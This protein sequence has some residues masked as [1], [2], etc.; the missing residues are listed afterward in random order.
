MNGE[1]NAILVYTFIA[2]I[3]LAKYDGWWWGVKGG[4]GVVWGNL[5]LPGGIHHG[6]LP[7]QEM[8]GGRARI[9]DQTMA[10]LTPCQQGHIT[11]SN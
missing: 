9:D 11:C 10:S 2:S 5:G 1:D 8:R 3:W 7:D 4:S 6:S